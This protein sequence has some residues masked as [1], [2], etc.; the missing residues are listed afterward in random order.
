MQTIENTQPAANVSIEVKET[1]PNFGNGRYSALMEQTWKDGQVVFKLPS[2]KAEKLARQVGSDFGAAIAGAVVDAKIGKSITKDGKTTLAEAAK[3]KG[4]TMTNALFALRSLGFA[5]ELGKYEFS[6]KLST[7][8]IVD[9]K[10]KEY[11][12]QL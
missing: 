9:G 6:W 11:L 4:V 3:V 5:A 2:D 8:V 7:L 1:K 12:E 10:L